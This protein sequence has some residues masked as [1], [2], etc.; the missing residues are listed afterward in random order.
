MAKKKNEKKQVKEKKSKNRWFKE[1]ISE[2]KKVVWPSKKDLLENT[3]VVISMVVIVAAII[4]VLDL[5][6]EA[7]N[8]FEVQQVE[9]IKNSTNSVVTEANETTEGENS[10]DTVSDTTESEQP[11]ES[12]NKVSE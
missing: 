2:L 9:K 1:F 12:E 3:V 4:F 10:A 5:A 8:K 7:L 11:A 6:F